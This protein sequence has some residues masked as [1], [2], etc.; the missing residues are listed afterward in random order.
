MGLEICH[1][2]YL[3]P[4]AYATACILPYKLWSVVRLH[5]AYFV[6]NISTNIT[7]ADNLNCGHSTIAELLDLWGI[8]VSFGV[9]YMSTTSAS[10]IVSTPLLHQFIWS[11]LEYS[12]L[13]VQVACS[14][15]ACQRQNDRGNHQRRWIQQQVRDIQPR[16]KSI[17]L[18]VAGQF[19]TSSL[20]MAQAVPK[21]STTFRKYTL[22][23]TLRNWTVVTPMGVDPW[24][25]RGTCPSFWS[26]LSP[27]LCPTTLWE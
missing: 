18:K 6:S 19:C 12:I 3:R 4:V 5:V 17:H 20:C 13:V 16:R 26:V 21:I 2:L 9:L 1:F 25:D 23:C 15:V 8:S 7:V 10:N 22:Q 14:G 27:V 24:V 11:L